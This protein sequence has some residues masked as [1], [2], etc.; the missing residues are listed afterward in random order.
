MQ[1]IKRTV[2]VQSP[3]YITSSRIKNIENGRSNFGIAAAHQADNL[4]WISTWKTAIPIT[5]MPFSLSLLWND[6][7]A[8]GPAQTTGRNRRSLWAVK[9]RG[10]SQEDGTKCYDDWISQNWQETLLLLIPYCK[11]KVI[12]DVVHRGG[13]ERLPQFRL[14]QQKNKIINN[15]KPRIAP[16]IR[17]WPFPSNVLHY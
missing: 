17:W 4:T 3:C 10:K 2:N 11:G 16:Y 6:T 1:D 14:G 13:R 7:T 15:S 9:F 12:W 5:S 8:T